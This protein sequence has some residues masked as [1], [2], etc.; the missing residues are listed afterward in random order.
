MNKVLAIVKLNQQML[1][2]ASLNLF[3]TNFVF[4][5]GALNSP[6]FFIGEAPGKKE[7]ELGI[8]FVGSS[9]KLL[10]NSLNSI[11]LK[12]ED[13]YITNLVK[14]R[15]PNNRNPREKEIS[16]FSPYLLKEIEIIDP[17]LI[18]PLGKFA[19]NFFFPNKLISQFQ[20][21]EMSY[22]NFKVFPIYHPAATLRNRKMK[23]EYDK[24]FNKLYKL[25]K[26][27]GQ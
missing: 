6:L 9:G 27:Y 18:I 13:V 17:K 22:K 8:P 24:S 1:S 4:G 10:N 23:E 3:E 2:D 16:L 7:D 12:R 25:I 26:K 15:P 14:K 19:F 21:K 20:G 11:K 5:Q